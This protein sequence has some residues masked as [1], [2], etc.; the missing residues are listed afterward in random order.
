MQLLF[1]NIRISCEIFLFA[2]KLSRILKILSLFIKVINQYQVTLLIMLVFFKAQ[3][4]FQRKEE[5][6]DGF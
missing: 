5:I 1:L 4:E 6:I 3:F 2:Y